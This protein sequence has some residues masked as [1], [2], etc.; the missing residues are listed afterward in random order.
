MT[1]LMTKS[2]AKFIGYQMLIQLPH[3]HYDN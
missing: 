1:V 2:V 3:N